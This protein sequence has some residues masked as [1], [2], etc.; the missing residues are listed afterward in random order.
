MPDTLIDIQS[1]NQTHSETIDALTT[2]CLEIKACAER[3]GGLPMPRFGWCSGGRWRAI[4]RWCQPI[5][6]GAW[7]FS[8]TLANEF[9]H[10]DVRRVDIASNLSEEAAAARL[11]DIIVSGTAETELQIDGTAIRAVRAWTRSSLL[12]TK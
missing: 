10:L 3:F 7:A 6:T 5:E 12:S 4:R 2:R 1:A 8:R 9:P 11:R